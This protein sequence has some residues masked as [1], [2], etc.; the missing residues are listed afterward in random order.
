MIERLK[1][2][3]DLPRRERGLAAALDSLGTP[4]GRAAVRGLSPS[5]A[6]VVLPSL[7]SRAPD[8]KILLL[9]P[10][11]KEAETL[12]ADLAFAAAATRPGAAR[13][14]RFPSLEADP[15]QELEPHLGVAC[16]RV[17][18]LRVLR[19]PG[20]AI[21]VAPVRALI[22][23]LAPPPAFDVYRFDLREK[24]TVRPDELSGFLLSAG[25]LRV[26][27]VSSMGEFSRRGGIIDVFPPEGSEPVRVEFWGEEI[28][29][30]R[31]FDPATQ[32]ST[33][34]TE[35]AVIT[36][37]REYPWD[38]AAFER[39][40]E[41]LRSRRAGRRRKAAEITTG[42]DDLAER[43]EALASGRTFPGFE[44]CVR[45]VEAS[46]ASIFDYA[47]RALL[48]SWEEGQILTELESVYTEMSGSLDLTEGFGMPPPEELLLPRQDLQGRVASARLRLAELELDD[49][50]EGRVARIPC[51]PPRH[52]RGRLQDLAADLKQSTGT[53]TLLLMESAGRVERLAEV[54]EEYG[55]PPLILDPATAAGSAGPALPESR[56][57]LAPGRLSQGFVLPQIGLQVLTEREVFGEHS[58]RE[59]TRRKVAAFS[60]DFRDLKIGD[61]V[62]HVEHGIGRYAGIARMGDGD[63]QRDF[64]LLHFEG[65]DRLYVPI[66]RLDLV[67]RYSG[68][69]GQKPHLDRLGGQGWER[70]KRKVRKAMEEMAKDLLELYA[71][72]RAARGHAFAA[73]TPWQKEFEDAFAYATTPD[74]E[75][76]IRETKSDMES[77]VVMDRLICG[78]VGFG[79][80]EVAMRG[81][82]KAVMEGKQVA[83]LCPTTVLAFQ[84]LT[85]F[86]E[87]F[88]SWPAAIEMVS[89]FRSPREMKAIL[90]GVAE[91]KVDIL[92]G[93]HRL[94][95]KDVSFRDLGL[96]IVDEEQRFGVAHKEAIKALRK[97]V[98]VLTLTA[99][100]IPRTLQMSLAGIR[101]MSVIET[102]PEN[103]LAIQTAV[104][105][106]REGVIGTAIRNELK[107]GGQ[108]YFVHNRVESIGS[109]ANLIRRIVPEARLDVAHGQMSEGM[110]ENTMIRFLQGDF[111]VLLATT[112]IE[113]G[114]DIP[115][116]NTILVNR[117]DRFGLAQLY[118]LRG[119]VG[120]SDR[121]AYAY[122]FVPARKVLTPV[123]RRR[124]KALQ[125]FT[126]LGS[127]FR[128]AAMDLEIRGAGNLLG[129]EQSGHIAAVGFE[130]YCQLLER[131]VREMKGEAPR[132]EIK[133]QVNLGIDIR[134]PEEYI[135]DFSERLALY[136][137][138]AGAAD[139]KEIG[140]I[141]DQ[142]RDLYGEIPRQAGNLLALAA[143]RLQAERIHVRSIDYGSGRLQVKFS[144][145]SPVDPDR[146][147]DLAGRRPG[148]SLT[149]QGILRMELPPASSA[150]EAERLQ[151][152]RDLLQGIGPYGSMQPTFQPS[153]VGPSKGDR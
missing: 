73:D 35:Q 64:M 63:A 70:T 66:D 142:I 27:L 116:V 77:D 43:V 54:L 80:T 3:L 114:L 103:R 59:T 21:L 122:L 9:V 102:P 68:L 130:M 5:A 139:E 152:V 51:A 136:K 47:P 50:G 133:T 132:P 65:R 97:T 107:R 52:Y 90:K 74:Q 1:A 53:T 112:I 125:E 145:D 17:Q 98:D 104:V 135:A 8:G 38:R 84:H 29:S 99:T 79:K 153:A 100:P 146:L 87:R 55:Q 62:V 15:Y 134:I 41:I 93:T 127:G 89:R 144:E 109:M 16:E 4:A 2:I 56:L 14:L 143:L 37:V 92:I 19:E 108:I 30:L 28:D 119:R 71:A 32:R 105:P 141:G 49:P 115:R 48:V 129:G 61:L 18:A 82:F 123:A 39:L 6:A 110:L 148:L 95:S 24:G 57:L 86:R 138:I 67:Q 121:R 88:S 25:Y 106:F 72:R 22:Y 78:D 44:A 118:Q 40:H 12:R 149:P 10:G 23:A 36:P 31:W 117:A 45:L 7:L 101:D 126:E 151:A 76:A 128:V 96:L 91:G 147:V 46:P 58:E 85:T 150:S 34:R 26:D 11:E 81:A 113:N 13:V 69:A 33:G 131:A 20:E 75:K 120:R 137:R 124:L 42:P 111:D 60:P 83:V 140:R 94:L